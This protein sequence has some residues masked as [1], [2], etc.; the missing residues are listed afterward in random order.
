MIDSNE[1][2]ICRKRGH[3]PEPLMKGQW[4]QC[5]WCGMWTRKVETTEE[6]EDAP[7]ENEIDF[8][9]RRGPKRT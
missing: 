7:P 9:Q 5:Q 1:L 2:A 6:R 3:S 4:V 8:I